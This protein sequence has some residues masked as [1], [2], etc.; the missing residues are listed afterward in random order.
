[1]FKTGVGIASFCRHRDRQHMRCVRYVAD[2]VDP[3]TEVACPDLPVG[4]VGVGSH[5][6]GGHGE[7]DDVGS[8]ADDHSAD[9][10]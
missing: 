3:A 5:N 9:G 10:G 1:M 2:D 6:F 4:A 7:A 8:D